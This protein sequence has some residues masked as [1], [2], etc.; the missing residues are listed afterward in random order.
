MGVAIRIFGLATLLIC[1]SGCLLAQ[2]HAG[3]D[4][5]AAG[6]SQRAPFPV[7][8]V[9]PP[10]AS[11]RS[12]GI[13]ASARSIG[14][15]ASA[16]IT[17][18]RPVNSIR[19]SPFIHG[20]SALGGP[21]RQTSHHPGRR[22]HRGGYGYVGYPYFPYLGYAE[23]GFDNFA[24]SAPIYPAEG[25]GVEPAAGNEVTRQLEQL[26]AQIDDLQSRLNEGQQG[27]QTSAASGTVEPEQPSAP[28]LT[29]VLSDGRTLKVQNYAV[30]GDTLWDLS[31]QPVRKIPAAKIDLPASSKASESS[32]VE[33][34]QFG[35]GT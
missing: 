18:G 27:K 21:W 3:S 19:Q 33:F 6:V 26:S 12:I 15:P 20:G 17:G 29:V 23:T 5:R 7:Q 10:S 28:P 30:V 32:G 8:P 1:V 2:H 11:A 22:D 9:V 4:G 31:S 13:P 34:P 14:I 24:E 25:I 35:P 16:Y